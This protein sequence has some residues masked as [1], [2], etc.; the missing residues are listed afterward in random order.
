M[1]LGRPSDKPIELIISQS[2]AYNRKNS[3]KFTIV[4]QL[5]DLACDARGHEQVHVLCGY[6]IY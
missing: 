3:V 5:S 2:E 1:R 4:T 6:G